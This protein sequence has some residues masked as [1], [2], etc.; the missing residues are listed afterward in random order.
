[1][2]AF[3]ANIAAKH[4]ANFLCKPAG[5][6]LLTLTILEVTGIGVVFLRDCQQGGKWGILDLGVVLRRYWWWCGDSAQYGGLV[7]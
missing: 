4:R 1:M 7:Y 2:P 6:L 5:T 3:K